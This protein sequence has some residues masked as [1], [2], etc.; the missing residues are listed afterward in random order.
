MLH[1]QSRFIFLLSI[2]L[3]PTF[4]MGHMVTPPADLVREVSTEEGLHAALTSSTPTV[5]LGYMDPCPHC[6]SIKPYF[7]VLAR[8]HPKIN[9]ITANGPKLIMHKKVAALTNNS[10]KIPGYPTMIFVYDGS[11]IGHVIGGNKQKLEKMVA[12]MASTAKQS[13]KRN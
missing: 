5:I 10:I 13:K 3:V 9:F 1:S 8:K 11:I 6:A 7:S 4:L 12:D 2:A